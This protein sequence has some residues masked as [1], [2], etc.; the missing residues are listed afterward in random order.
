MNPCHWNLNS[1]RKHTALHKY[2]GMKSGQARPQKFNNPSDM[3]DVKR[4]EF[5]NK[6]T[7]FMA[8]QNLFTTS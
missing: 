7:F 3:S 2:L 5:V 8:H 6:T 1:K 4:K